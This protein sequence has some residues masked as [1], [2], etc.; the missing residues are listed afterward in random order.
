[1]ETYP[2][3]FAI[4]VTLN[5][6][7]D[8]KDCLISLLDSDLR[9]AGIV[10]VDNGST[11]GSIEKLK[12]HFF[13]VPNVHFIVNNR[14]LGFAKGVNIGLRFA[15]SQNAH[16][17]ALLNNDVIIDKN[18][19]KL[20]VEESH[21]R[22]SVGIAGPRIHYFKSPECIWHGGGYFNYLKA[23]VSIPEKNKKI[24]NETYG[25]KAKE[26]T[27]ISGC[28]MLIKSSVFDKI[29]FFDEDYFLYEE[30]L[31]FCLRTLRAGFKI[32]YVPYAKAWHK[33][34]SVAKDRT[35]AFVLYHMARSRLLV[36]RKNFSLLYFFYGL[37][38]HLFLYTPF[39]FWQILQGSKS[40]ESIF[41]WLHGTWVGFREALC[42]SKK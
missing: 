3:I 24:K 29:G 14:N 10:V 9:L 34:D 4:I 13:C 16:Y 39:R 26:V 23:G 21:R 35:S 37:F 25:N 30:D 2:K 18:C 42:K 15:A 11:D 12:K 17:I 31:D 33:I 7:D 22:S 36:L 6:Y 5:N 8:T 20:L 38:I 27:F 40:L 41:A 19:L 32:L 1:M 28:V